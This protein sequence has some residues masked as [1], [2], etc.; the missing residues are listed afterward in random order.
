M[1]GDQPFGSTPR[2]RA[3]AP[4]RCPRCGTLAPLIYVHGH[5]Q[6]TAC[7]SN[8]LDCCQGAACDLAPDRTV[9]R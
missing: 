9:D 8:I 6:C 5:A 4:Q 7:G 2:N 1:D 3:S